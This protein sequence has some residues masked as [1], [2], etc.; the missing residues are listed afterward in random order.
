[1]IYE[2]VRKVYGP[3]LR[4]DGRQHIQIIFNDGSRKVV[5]YPR[6]L[7]ENHIGRILNL[8]ETVHHIDE[9]ITNNNISNL[10]ILNREEHSKLHAKKL[11]S[12]K[13]ICEVCN[14]EFELVGRKLHDAAIN[15]VRG[16]VGPFCGRSCAGKASHNTEQ[17]S[18]QKIKRE[19]YK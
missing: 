18:I 4:K 16:K 8:N 3:Y 19:Y 7:L 15:R 6:Y 17:Y 2:N 13:F 1:M 11:I 14:T 9:D 12:Q 10:E 5:S